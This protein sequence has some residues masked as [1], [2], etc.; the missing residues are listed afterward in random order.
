MK[1]ETNLLPTRRSEWV[2]CPQCQAEWTV[3]YPD[4]TLETCSDVLEQQ[5]NARY[6]SIALEDPENHDRMYATRE[7]WLDERDPKLIHPHMW[8]DLKGQHQLLAT[9]FSAVRL[10]CEAAEALDDEGLIVPQL[11]EPICTQLEGASYYLTNQ[12][13]IVRAHFWVDL[14]TW[15][16]GNEDRLKGYAAAMFAEGACPGRIAAATSTHPSDYKDLAALAA[17]RALLG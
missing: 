6:T 1:L 10:L 13:G 9:Y 11:V 5:W 7:V 4:G 3:K 17:E 16:Y 8:G 12:V 2:L 14:E 15:L